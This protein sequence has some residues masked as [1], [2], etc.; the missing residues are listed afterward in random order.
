MAHQLGVGLVVYTMVR[1]VFA[2]GHEHSENTVG[3][4]EIKSAIPIVIFKMKIT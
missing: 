4:P 2:L 3:L 1:G